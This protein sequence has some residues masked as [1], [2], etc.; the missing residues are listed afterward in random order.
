MCLV[1]IKETLV[2]YHSHK[3]RIIS[4]CNFFFGIFLCGLPAIYYYDPPIHFDTVNILV[5]FINTCVCFVMLQC[6]YRFIQIRRRKKI[7]KTYRVKIGLLAFVLVA[8]SISALILYSSGYGGINGLMMSGNLIRSSNIQSTNSLTFFK[9]FIP[10][11]IVASL[12][13][14]NY[15]FVL[16]QNNYKNISFWAQLIFL[17]IPSIIISYIYI[18]AND[19]RLLAGMYI[20]FFILISIKHKYEFVGIPFKILLV[21]S[22]FWLCLAWSL[23]IGSE[24]I[25][26][27]YRHGNVSDSSDLGLR[28]S[29]IHELS[30]IVTGTDK[31]IEKIDYTSFSQFMIINDFTN[32]LFAWLP[33]SLKPTK[34]DDVWDLNTNYINPSLIGQAPTCIVAQSYYDLGLLGIIIIPFFWG[35]MIKKLEGWLNG[36]HDVFMNTI[37]MVIAFY[38]AKTMVYFS[39]YNFMMNVFFIFLSW[40]VYKALSHKNAKVQYKIVQQKRLL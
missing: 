27:G 18:L 24:T 32:G 4:L 35:G 8:I 22:L 29:V 3:I 39:L 15:I 14:Y 9:H 12:L 5:G 34:F 7:V 17:F 21:A 19:G 40:L 20:V 37:Y 1:I 13:L 25:M 16:K 36:C 23:M 33:T 38:I 26:V 10:L 30:F 2:I 6:G 11:S 28:E 31:S